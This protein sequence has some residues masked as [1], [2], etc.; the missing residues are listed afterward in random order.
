MSEDMYYDFPCDLCGKD[1]GY[2]VPYVREYT[3]GQILHI[4]KSCGLIHAK[5]RR[6]V[7]Q[8]VGPYESPPD[9]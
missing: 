4:C 9:L 6:R 5:K 7:H 2:E 1:D 8:Q 3:G